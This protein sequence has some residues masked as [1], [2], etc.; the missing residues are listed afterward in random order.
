MPAPTQSRLR[1]IWGSAGNDVFAV[2]DSGTA[3][4]FDGVSWQALPKPTPRDL[5]ALWGR[6]PTEVYAVGDSGTVVRYDGVAW[7]NSVDRCD[8]SGCGR[9]FLDCDDEATADAIE[10]EMEQDANVVSYDRR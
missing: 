4:R 10:S 2:G 9:V 6:G 5:R 7:R 1:A 3:L 8:S